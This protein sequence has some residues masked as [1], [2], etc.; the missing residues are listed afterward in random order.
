MIK[1][2]ILAVTGGIATGKSTFSRE[3]AARIN[4]VLYCA[5]ESVSRLLAGDAVVR[6]EVI[7]A[8]GPESYTGDHPNRAWL[9]DRV[10]GDDAARHR[11]EAILHPRV[12]SQWEAAGGECRRSGRFFVAD[13]P[14]LYEAG[15]AGFFDAVI[16]VSCSREVRW[17]RLMMRPGI[18]AGTGKKMIASQLPL[19]TKEGSSHYLIWNDGVI[20]ALKAQAGELARLLAD[21]RPGNSHTSS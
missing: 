16:C 7:R 18:D 8:L 15:A 11:L 20:D 5:D 1:P 14:L 12:K 6:G 13:V 4:A 19:A 10:F 21:V 17:A 2:R 9:R 3:L